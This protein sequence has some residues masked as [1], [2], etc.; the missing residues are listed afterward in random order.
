MKA[1]VRLSIVT[2]KDIFPDF[3]QILHILRIWAGNW[4]LDTCILFLVYMSQ[5]SSITSKD[6][7]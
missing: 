5:L 1:K 6:K 3:V 2:V 4:M 7:Q